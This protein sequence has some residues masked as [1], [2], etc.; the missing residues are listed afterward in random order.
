MTY[1]CC[2]CANVPNINS[3]RCP[4]SRAAS[5][6]AGRL[7]PRRCTMAARVASPSVSRMTASL[8]D[9]LLT[10]VLFG[11]ACGVAG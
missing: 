9:I 2:N 4:A 1:R 8:P 11:L 6:S 5:V 3:Q 10:L 7:G